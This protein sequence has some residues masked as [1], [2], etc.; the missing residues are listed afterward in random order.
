M[1][2]FK[3]TKQTENCPQCGSPLKL[4]RGKQ[5]LF[6]GCSAYPV[7]DYLKPLHQA[8]HVIKRLDEFC[9]ECQAPLQLKQGHFG[10]FI[11]CSN[12]PDCHFIVHDE[13]DLQE[14]FDCPEC[15]RHKLVVRTGR[16]GKAF[17]GCAGYPECKFI[18]PSKPLKKR[19]PKCACAL[20]T[21]KKVRGKSYYLCANRQCQHLFSE[22]E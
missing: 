14:E 19:C 11:G 2:L 1:S 8:S 13:P 17:Y 15:K 20:A 10:M 4:K 6:L 16:S 22:N 3:S 5:G 12:Y 9:P 7:C 21:F 18:L